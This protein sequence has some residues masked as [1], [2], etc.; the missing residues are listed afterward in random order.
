MVTNSTLSSFIVP[1]SVQRGD[2]VIAVSTGGK[3]PALAAQIQRELALTYDES[4][5]MYVA[6]LGKLRESIQ[7]KVSDETKRKA[8]LKA[9]LEMSKEELISYELKI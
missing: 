2:L 6:K 3:S 4:F 1:S 9:L 5:A 8:L 7:E